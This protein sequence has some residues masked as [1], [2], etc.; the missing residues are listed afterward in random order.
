MTVAEIKK[1]IARLSPREYCELISE[2]VPRSN[3]AWDRQ[4]IAD[5]E[6][7]KLDFVDRNVNTA[8]AEETTKPL[9]KGFEQDA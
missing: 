1:A 5:A 4:M 3:E 6:S 2:F 9:E 7:G 8:I